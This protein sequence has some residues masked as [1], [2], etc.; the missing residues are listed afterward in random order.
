[1]SLIENF[2]FS[3][4]HSLE[5]GVHTFHRGGAPFKAGPC[6]P[7]LSPS[8]GQQ[9]YSLSVLWAWLCSGESWEHTGNPTSFLSPGDTELRN[10]RSEPTWGSKDP[11]WASVLFCDQIHF[12]AQFE[13]CFSATCQPPAIMP[14]AEGP[15]MNQTEIVHAVMGHMVWSRA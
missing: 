7:P 10:Q 3:V 11:G 14:G 2:C 15:T 13:K 9:Q 5:V 6:C 4:R 1:M 8:G 12:K